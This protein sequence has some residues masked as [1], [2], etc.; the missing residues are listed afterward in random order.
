MGFLALVCVLQALGLTFGIIS[1]TSQLQALP[2][3]AQV[4]KTLW[5]LL[6]GA[7][8]LLVGAVCLP[9]YF[10]W[11]LV[12]CRWHCW[13]YLSKALLSQAAIS[14]LVLAIYAQWSQQMHLHFWF[15]FFAFYWLALSMAPLLV[16]WPWAG[17]LVK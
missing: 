3:L 15:S 4:G 6:F 2:A 5:P 14:V 17:K 16:L 7:V 10:A 9:L 11:H 1:F 13:Q 12:A 8:L